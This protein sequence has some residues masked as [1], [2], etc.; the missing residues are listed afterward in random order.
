MNDR[1]SENNEK[2]LNAAFRILLNHGCSGLSFSAVAS[3]VGISRRPLID[4]F[5]DLSDLEIKVW[6]ETVG[7]AFLTW[8][9]DAFSSFELET[10]QSDPSFFREIFK[11]ALQP[12][13]ELLV[14]IELLI[15][16]QFNE[17]LRD[18]I[19]AD[20]STHFPLWFEQDASAAGRNGYLM[21]V[22]VGFLLTSR[23]LEFE[24][25]TEF[26]IIVDKIITQALLNRQPI[27]LPPDTADYLDTPLNFD[28]DDKTLTSLLL[29]TNEV[30]G[31]VG[32]EKATVDVIVKRAN[33]SQGAL[34]AR[35]PTKLDLFIE[36][37]RQH[38]DLA[39]KRNWEF[40]MDLDRKYGHGIGAC[41]LIREASRSKWN[42]LRATNIEQYRLTWYNQL[43]R[44]N[45]ISVTSRFK[46]ERRRMLD[47]SVKYEDEVR[48]N[49]NDYYAV[50]V[51]MGMVFLP[52]IYP[53]A[54]K[55][56][57]DVMLL[58]KDTVVADS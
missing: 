37:T 26:S 58:D 12:S 35:F 7:P 32:Y 39:M 13:N 10:L 18:A 20:L 29:A 21:M 9:D 8:L 14:A 30:I 48:R 28:L 1:K 33:S 5:D 49:T 47:E 17:K 22:L 50:A 4:R 57:F 16:T 6:Q 11:T 42:R 55:L 3:A 19:Q 44:E 53:E 15:E 31:E 34:F 27:E 51:G 56:P 24:D 46:E 43:F 40:R 54:T 45:S 52:L 36:T 2:I 25:R 41:I 23:S 38:S